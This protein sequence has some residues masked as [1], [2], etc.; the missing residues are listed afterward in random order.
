MSDKM[1]YERGEQTRL[2]DALDGYVSDLDRYKE[3]FVEA[4]DALIAKGW[5]D[6]ESLVS[7]KQKADG[8]LSELS[9]THEKLQ[10]VRHAIDG[11]FTNAFDADKKVYNSF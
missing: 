6:S 11:A 2:I 4:R 3:E 9:D 8:L 1:L 5:E 10:K 7:F